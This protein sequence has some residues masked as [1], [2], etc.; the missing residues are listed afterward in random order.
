MT[1]G[2]DLNFNMETFN[3]Y[4]NDKNDDLNVQTAQQTKQDFQDYYKTVL[5]FTEHINAYKKEHSG[6]D[7]RQEVGRLDRKRRN[8]HNNCLSDID[9]LNK[10]A[11]MDG[12]KPFL[13]GFEEQNRTDIGDAIL[14]T[15]YEQMVKGTGNKMPAID[16]SLNSVTKDRDL[17]NK[18]NQMLDGYTKYPI[19]KHGQNYQFVDMFTGRQPDKKTLQNYVKDRSK[20]DSQKLEILKQAMSFV[21]DHVGNLGDTISR[22]INGYQHSAQGL[23][24]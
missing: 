22:E 4:L 18:Y 21:S 15:G 1:K 17:V 10:M 24:L 6:D 12:L 2:K 14:Q 3:H 20:G 9:M 19:I 5:H 23:Q 13:E 16:A 11:Q 8:I 7:Y